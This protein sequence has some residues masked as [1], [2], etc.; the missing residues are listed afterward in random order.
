MKALLPDTNFW[1][2]GRR[3]FDF[4]AMA[5]GE[6]YLVLRPKKV[7]NELDDKQHEGRRS[8]RSRARDVVFSLRE[9]TRRGHVTHDRIEAS[10]DQGVVYWFVPDAKVDPG[11]SADV[12]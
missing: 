9:L 8:L 1:L 4:E 7:L 2:H 12:D 6:D 10:D 5:D 11:T 3:P